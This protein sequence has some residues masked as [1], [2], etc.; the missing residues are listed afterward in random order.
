MSVLLQA[1]EMFATYTSQY[2]L[3]ELRLAL[4]LHFSLW[5]FF[6]YIQLYNYK[7]ITIFKATAYLLIVHEV[8]YIIIIVS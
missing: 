4:R 1:W 3:N 6:M 7:W 5:T 2:K 8:M